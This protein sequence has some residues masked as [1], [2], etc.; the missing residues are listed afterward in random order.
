M[1]AAIL[2]DT[3]HRYDMEAFIRPWAPPRQQNYIFQNANIVDPL[4]GRVL[5]NRTLWISGGKILSPED[6][7][8][9]D[10]DAHVIDC[11]GLYLC[12]GLIDCHVHL[13]FPPGGATLSAVFSA[14]ARE[15]ILRT[16]YVCR[17]ML[18]NGFTTVR[19]TAGATY[20]LKEAI[21]EGVVQGPRLFIAGRGLSQSGGH[22][23]FR[24]RHQEES[25]CGGLI[26]AQTVR[27]CDGVPACL[28]A[29][30]EELRTGSDFLK[31]MVGGGV[32]SPSDRI[33][34]LQFTAEEIRAFTTS[35]NNRKTYVTAHAYTPEAIQLAVQNGVTC[36]EHGN[37]IDAATAK[38]MAE[39]NVF[40]TPTLITYSEMAS[41]RW[42]NFLPQGHAEKNLQVLDAGLKSL[43]IAHDAGVTICFGT[44]L[45]GPLVAAQT[46]EF[47]LR[48][49]VLS[50][51]EILRSATVNAAK[52]LRQEECLG[53]LRPR[54]AADVLLL[55][56][57]P[58]EDIEVFDRPKEHL[59]MVMKAGRVE[60]GS[61]PVRQANL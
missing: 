61:M 31:I 6:S 12:P 59:L 11:A 40:L 45:L 23:D 41:S 5:E 33:T 53:Q 34:D 49:Q 27:V 29:A 36:I 16:P 14:D 54:F 22:G 10:K 30:R 28:K 37:L 8:L 32:A 19:D 46:K 3:H 35:A 60:F 21:E 17:E 48:A 9:P 47:G 2:P 57:N 15:S 56:R 55:N 42:G 7:T 44:D 13:M 39:N 1:K 43:Q 58:L 50:P 20:A 18:K 52:L 26:S 4:A 38:M 24:A 25:C 51:A